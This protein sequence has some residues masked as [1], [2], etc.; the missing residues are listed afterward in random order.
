MAKNGSFTLHSYY[1]LYDSLHELVTVH[2]AEFQMTSPST[3]TLTV[4]SESVC[5]DETLKRF[6]VKLLLPVHAAHKVPL[7]DV[8]NDKKFHCIYRF[9]CIICARHGNEFVYVGQSKNFK[10]RF[11]SHTGQ[12][13]RDWVKSEERSTLSIGNPLA[14]STPRKSSSTVFDH[15]VEFH[16]DL[17]ESEDD[18]KFRDILEVDIVH[19]FSEI[20]KDKT[21]KT[22]RSNWETF[23]QWLFKSTENETENETENFTE[24][25]TENV[26]EKATDDGPE[27]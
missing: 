14:K 27:C 2:K 5:F 9:R 25:L 13:L 10:P 22:I 17:V 16:P 3:I 7:K 4:A 1:K 24:N 6:I 18:V 15:P 21:E 19:R 23:S 26:T 12:M 8:A 20:S 11:E